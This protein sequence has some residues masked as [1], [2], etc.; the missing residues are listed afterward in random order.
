MLE[1]FNKEENLNAKLGY[2]LFFKKISENKKTFTVVLIFAILSAF[3][4]ASSKYFLGKIIDVLNN[5]S[6][7]IFNLVSID[8]P[9][10]IISLYV[11]TFGLDELSTAFL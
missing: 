5:G 6:V 10:L 2:K 11:F 8:N 1:I 9:Y 3:G 7:N 4:D